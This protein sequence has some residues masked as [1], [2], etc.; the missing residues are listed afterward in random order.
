MQ[1]GL[2]LLSIYALV[3]LLGLTLVALNP[4]WLPVLLVLVM[5]TGNFDLEGRSLLA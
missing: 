3:G 1:V 5:P 4:A 2:D